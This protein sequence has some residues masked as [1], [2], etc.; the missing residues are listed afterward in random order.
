MPTLPVH[1]REKLDF[2]YTKSISRSDFL[3]DS[4]T[5][6][7]L[8]SVFCQELE[9]TGFRFVRDRESDEIIVFHAELASKTLCFEQN[10][11]LKI[12]WV[13]YRKCR[14]SCISLLSRSR[15]NLKP[16]FSSSWQKS[17]S[18]KQGVRQSDK[19]IGPRY[20]WL[21]MFEGKI[22]K[23]RQIATNQRAPN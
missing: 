11:L 3:S 23:S 20:D 10:M 13:R 9:K 17:N 21:K 18:K 14:N 7:F 5:P 8:E 4:L 6:C 12:R 15:R 19:K 16:V 2:T 1:F 22:M